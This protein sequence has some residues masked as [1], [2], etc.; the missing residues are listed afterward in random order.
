[1]TDETSACP[2]NEQTLP[3]DPY[4]VE[5]SANQTGVCPCG[6]DTQWTIT[7]QESW[8]KERTEASQSWG[9]LAGKEL[10]EDIC[11]LMNVA[12]EHSAEVEHD[13]EVAESASPSE[14]EAELIV[15]QR[16]A[17]NALRE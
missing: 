2:S 9:G 6:H 15:E 12:F 4:R 13:A 14:T 10:A 7:W 8:Q 1:M 3:D 5:P 17:S 16:L 11:E